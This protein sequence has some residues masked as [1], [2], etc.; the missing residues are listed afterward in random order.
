MCRRNIEWLGAEFR[1]EASCCGLTPAALRQVGS[2]L[3]RADARSFE[4][5]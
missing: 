3:L 4:A 1:L 2:K 5:G